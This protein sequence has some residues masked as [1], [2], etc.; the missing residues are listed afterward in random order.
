MKYLDNIP[1]K[2]KFFTLLLITTVGFGLISYISYENTNKLKAKLDYTY[3][4]NFL[5]IMKLKDMI[6]LYETNISSSI[7]KNSHSIYSNAY[8]YKMLRNTQIDINEMWTQYKSIYKSKEELAFINYVERQIHTLEEKIQKIIQTNNIKN[9]DTEAIFFEIGKITQSLERLIEYELDVAKATRLEV[10]ALHKNAINKIFS[11][12]IF[13][14]VIAF[15]IF[16]PLLRNIEKNQTRLEL[17]ANKLKSIS[18]KDPMTKLYN[19]RYFDHTIKRLFIQAARYEKKIAFM[20]LDID[21]FKQ[22]N[23]TYGHQAGDETIKSVAKVLELSVKRSNDYA[24]R[25]GG[26]EFAVLLYDIDEQNSSMIAQNIKEQIEALQIAHE[27]NKASDFVTISIGLMV[28]N[29][30]KEHLDDQTIENLI[31]NADEKLY[32]AKQNGR[33]QVFS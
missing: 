13:V 26:E 10:N 27:K 19:R 9:I 1:F 11:I 21:F 32:K 8:T 30:Q 17:L 4:G 14:T 29:I 20:M 23:D 3:F 28:Q 2:V 12:A 22:Y 33:N 18:I 7:Y 25:L 6:L 5:P 24:F 31:K 15:I 16:I